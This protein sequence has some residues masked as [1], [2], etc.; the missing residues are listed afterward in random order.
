VTNHE[1]IASLAQRVE[2]LESIE[3]IR[4]LRSRYHDLVN[5]DQGS[6]LYELFAPNA[7]VAYSGRPVVTGRDNIREFFRTFP[8]Q[9]ARQFI[10]HHQVEVEGD[11][12]RGHC[13]LDGRPV[14]NGESLFVVGRFDDTYIRIDGRWCFQSVRLTVLYMVTP[15]AGWAEHLPFKGHV[16]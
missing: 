8:V 14:R 7:T 9:W 15:G 11:R 2:R 4:A 12:G 10:H 3:A 13:D 1:Q 5:L 16:T 6:Q